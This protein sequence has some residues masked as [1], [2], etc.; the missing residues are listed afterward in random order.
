MIK[1]LDKKNACIKKDYVL[2]YKTVF[3]GK[4]VA[5]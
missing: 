4:E 2:I 1:K 3:F 5:P